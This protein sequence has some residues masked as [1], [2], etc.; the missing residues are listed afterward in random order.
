MG[1]SK[2]ADALEVMRRL[3]KLYPGAHIALVFTNPLELLVAT[4]LLLVRQTRLLRIKTAS[5]DAI[6]QDWKKL[7][8]PKS[9][10]Q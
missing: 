3:E 4:S 5:P 2:P 6:W 10:V 1:V 8:L 9:A 7:I